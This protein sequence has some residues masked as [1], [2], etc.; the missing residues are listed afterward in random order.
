M[1]SIH[2]E[3]ELEEAE[4]GMTDIKNKR[5]LYYILKI[6]TAKWDLLIVSKAIQVDSKNR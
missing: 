5:L 1:T 2:R 4:N 6:F 3:H